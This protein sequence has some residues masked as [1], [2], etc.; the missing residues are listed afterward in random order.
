MALSTTDKNI[1]EEI[2]TT[3][4]QCMNSK[5][6]EKCP[7]RAICLPEFLNPIPPSQEQ[8][9]KMAQ[10]VLTHHYLIDDEVEI[11]DI[12]KDFKWDKK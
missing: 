1:L 8:R 10:D 11:E 5:R 3:D 7:F 2:V 12:R 6:C 4:G 9:L